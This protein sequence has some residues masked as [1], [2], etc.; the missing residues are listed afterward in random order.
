M[1]ALAYGMC[2]FVLG[3]CLLYNDDS[4]EKFNRRAAFILANVTLTYHY[5][6]QASVTTADRE[7]HYSWSVHRS[8]SIRIQVGTVCSSC[9][10]TSA[11]SETTIGTTLRS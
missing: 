9:A 2:A 10:E 7:S 4:V 11:K 5:A 6:F 1:E 8:I 3:L